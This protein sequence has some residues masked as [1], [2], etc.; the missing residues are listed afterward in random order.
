MSK[1]DFWTKYCRAEY[2]LR[3]R[4]VVAAAAEPTEDE[5]LAVFL[6]HDEILANEARRKLRQVDPTLDM[7]ADQGHVAPFSMYQLK[8]LSDP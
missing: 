1:M 3:T 8:M 4:N 7:E 5:E 6:K 2:L